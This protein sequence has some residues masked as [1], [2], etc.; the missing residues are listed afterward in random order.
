MLQ[1]IVTSHNPV[2]IN[3]VEKWFIRMFP[4]VDFMIT[5]INSPSNVKDQPSS[6]EETL[7]WA[8]NRVKNAKVSHPWFDYYFGLEWWIQ[9][10]D[11][12][13]AVLWRVYCEN[14]QDQKWKW[15]SW[16][17]FLPQ[18]VIELLSQWMELWTADDIVFWKTNSKQ[19]TGSIGILTNDVLTR[20]DGFITWVINSLIPFKNEKLYFDISL[21]AYE[22]HK[23]F[24]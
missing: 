4:N 16:W 10:F 14:S 8:I 2:K 20:E 15:M 3:A 11:W 6:I 24:N 17:H 21:D 18:P 19:S 12:E 9:N 7:Q 23:F 22:P 1:I 13:V 5:P